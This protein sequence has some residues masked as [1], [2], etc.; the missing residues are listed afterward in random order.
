MA[1][2]KLEFLLPKGVSIPISVTWANRTDL[3]KE[4][5]VRGHIGISFDAASLLTIGGVASR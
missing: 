3:I 1:Q 5:I 2:A 4:K